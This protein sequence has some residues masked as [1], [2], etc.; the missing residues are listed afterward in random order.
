MQTHKQDAVEERGTTVPTYPWRAMQVAHVTHS[1]LF[2]TSSQSHLDPHSSCFVLYYTFPPQPSEPQ[3][4]PSTLPIAYVLIPLSQVTVHSTLSGKSS[5][6]TAHYRK[7]NRGHLPGL[8]TRYR[9]HLPPFDDP[10]PKA[11]GGLQG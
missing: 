1:S 5:L 6:G 4:N 9:R 2:A 7:Q 8:M 10:I 3:C 11:Q